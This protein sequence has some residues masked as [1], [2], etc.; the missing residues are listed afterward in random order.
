MKEGKTS[1]L[2]VVS[3]ASNMVVLC[4]TKRLVHAL[5]VVNVVI[6]FEIAH[7][8][9]ILKHRNQ[10]MESLDQGPKGECLP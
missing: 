7:E 9:R 5:I 3:A 4:A 6:L 10:I 2:H 1:S 8:Q